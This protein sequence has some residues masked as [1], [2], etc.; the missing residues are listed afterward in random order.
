MREK[1][2]RMKGGGVNLKVQCAKKDGEN[3]RKHLTQYT[4]TRINII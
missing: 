3:V 2:G 1:L 4:S